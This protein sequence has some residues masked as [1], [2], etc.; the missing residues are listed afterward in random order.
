MAKKVVALIKL[1]LPAGKANPAPPVGPALGQHGVNIMAFCKEY[2]ARTQDKVGLVIPVE[3]SVFEDRSFTFILK[4][5]PAS[6]LIKKAAG[7]ERGSGEPRT[8]KVGSITRA[9][10]K[11]IAETKMPDLNAND[12]EAAMNIVEGTARNM[13]V[14]VGD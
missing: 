10:L 7:I 1:A 4:T 8:K 5:P 14:T 11:E 6:V 3:I 9:Q 2:N 12:I 13:G